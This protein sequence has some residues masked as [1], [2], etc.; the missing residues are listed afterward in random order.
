MNDKD[1]Q[2]LIIDDDEVDRLTI[3]RHLGRSQFQVKLSESKNATE[4]IKFLQKHTFN[5]IFLDYRLPD[6]DG[7]SLV[8]QL[9]LEGY[10]LPIIVLTGQGD[11]QVA[12]ELMKAG[13]SDY[14]VK[15]R[16]SPD[17]LSSLIRNS[18]N[19]YRAEQRIRAAQQQLRQTNLIL[20]QQNLQLE[21]QRR[22]IEQQ[23]LRLL[24]AN[25]HKTEFLATVTHELRTPLN[26]IMG[27]SQILKNESRGKL[28]KC[29]SGMVDRIFSNGKT[30]LNLVNDIL[31]MSTIESHHLELL[32]DY[33]DLTDLVTEVTSELRLFS[34]RKR[35]KLKLVVRLEQPIVYNDR[36]RLKQVLTNLVSNAIK[37]TERGYVRIEVRSLARNGIEILVSDTGI[38]ISDHQLEYIFQPFRQGNQSIKRRHSGTGLGLAISYSL[39]NMMEG[40]ITVCSELGKGTTFRIQIPRKIFDSKELTGED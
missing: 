16:L 34:E 11:E 13:A 40:F 8:R 27:F 24:D 37:F 22:Q 4:A 26:S 31:D 6:T 23:N 5:F 1:L 18:L 35:L 29:Q 21:E 19:V 14:L 10:Y 12:V 36:H 20:R 7:I 38:G 9:R 15:S 2:V 25:Q 3:R 33:F 32:P 17:I 28:N 30:L 39:V